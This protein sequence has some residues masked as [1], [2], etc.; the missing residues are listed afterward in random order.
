MRQVFVDKGSLIIQKVAQPKLDE[1]SVL[2]SVHY[3]FM[4]SGIEAA[5]I[6][7]TQN[8]SLLVNIP[9][10][11]KIALSS[12][13]QYG[14]YGTKALL[15]DV[16]KNKLQSLGFSCSG[17][18]IAVGLKVTGFKIG[19]FVAC[20][21]A[22]FA[23]HADVVCVPENLVV[24]VSDPERLKQASIAGLGAI[25]LQAVRRAQLQI[26][27][28]VCIQGL[29]L[30]GQ[31]TAQFAKA[32]GCTVV[33]IDILP[34]RLVLAKELGI[35]YVF[36][37]GYQNLQKSI[38][39][40]TYHKG[41][42]CTIITA[43]SSSDNLVQQAMELTR[44]KGKVVVVGD[45]GLKL[46]RTPFYQ[47]E[48]DFLI[49]CSYGPGAYDIDYEY[50]AK[51]YP[52]SYVRWTEKRNMQA[53]LDLMNTKKI[54]VDRLITQE[55][56]VTQAMQGY[57]A[58][59]EKKALGVVLTY[60]PKNDFEFVP[61]VKDATLQKVIA[62][63]PTKKGSLNVAVAGIDTTLKTKLLPVIARL[64][65]VS[66]R[67]I[68]DSNSALAQNIAR[69]YGATKTTLE[70]FNLNSSNEIDVLMVST[71][72]YTPEEAINTLSCGKALL[73]EKPLIKT[74]EQF[75]QLSKFLKQNPKVP[76]C[77][78]YNRSCAPFIQKIKWETVN[79]ISPLMIAYRMNVATKSQDPFVKH[80]AIGNVIDQACHIFDL[81][82]FLI[83]SNPRSVSVEALRSSHDDLFPTDNFSVQI[84]FDDG[85][86]CSL[87]Y[88]SIGNQEL[89][90]ERMELFFDG[91]SIIMDD[92]LSLTGYG[93]ARA[94]NETVFVQDK[95]HK[96]LVT[97]FFESLQKEQYQPIM[98]VDRINTVI[99]LTLIVDQLV[100]KGGGEQVL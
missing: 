55:I 39:F 18:V 43:S 73:L 82:Y 83:D 84:T 52:Y 71:A 88:T 20:A 7:Q 30:L 47:K 53:V 64:S 19:D 92:F 24:A 28:I 100:C 3:S 22:D 48:I 87:L 36:E 63:M 65:G 75:E 67:A 50:H 4:S 78:D 12:L 80:T 23:P 42:D 89:G 81:F 70:S 27:E 33:G 34:D 58:L 1:H 21:G 79:R 5:I 35:D 15:H 98:N 99:K 8:K 26:S 32:A 44:K 77:I 45:I 95:G 17:R 72:S 31:L 14:F 86:L 90:R 57:N 74:F 29:G 49:S 10:K 11:I 13:A 91:K 60:L 94:F 56:P 46:E 62:F 37:A 76:F 97:Q 25:A 69:M 9:Q 68:T 93:I 38:D 59:K 16:S 61:A 66:I 40:L 41:V 96:N 6:A 51:D 54:A 2:V 85:S